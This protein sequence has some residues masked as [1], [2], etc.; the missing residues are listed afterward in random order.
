M[1]IYIYIYIHY[2][3]LDIHKCLFVVVVVTLLVLTGDSWIHLHIFSKSAWS[4]LGQSYCPRVSEDTMEDIYY[5]A[6]SRHNSM[7]SDYKVG[8]NHD[9]IKWKHF[10]RY[11]PF[12]RGIHR[13]PVDSPSQRPATRCFE[14]FFD[15]RPNKR[16]SKQS[17]RRWFETPSRSVWRH[18]NA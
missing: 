13:W 14:V 8:L 12:A 5:K 18:C 1:Y 4:T 3:P 6:I 15:L 17:R 7:Q 10:P 11:W 16:F 2:T 9:V